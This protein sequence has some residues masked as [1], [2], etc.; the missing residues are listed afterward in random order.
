MTF[1]Q[2]PWF[3]YGALPLLCLVCLFLTTFVAVQILKESN[4]MGIRLQDIYTYMN[5]GKPDDN[6][7]M[8]VSI[9][10]KDCTLEATYSGEAY[11][12]VVATNAG[13]GKGGKCQAFAYENGQRPSALTDEL[14]NRD[15]ERAYNRK[16]AL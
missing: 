11:Q 6:S 8:N 5:D 2:T 1:I 12:K 7:Q 9:T 16:Q 4:Y 14:V 10:T 15:L 3:K 13:K